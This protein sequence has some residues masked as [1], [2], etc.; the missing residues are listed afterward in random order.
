MGGAP[1]T[2]F[3]LLCPY[4]RRGGR[5][6]WICRAAWFCRPGRSYHPGEVAW[7]LSVSYHPNRPSAYLWAVSPRT[8]QVVPNGGSGCDPIFCEPDRSLFPLSWFI[9]RPLGYLRGQK[10]VSVARITGSRLDGIRA[11]SGV[12]Q[13]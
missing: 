5:I 10:P 13:T 4:Q 12:Q 8:C 6:D 3:P 2:S 11:C 1:G 9:S 7:S